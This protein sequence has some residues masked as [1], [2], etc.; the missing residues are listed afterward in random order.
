VIL[1]A[2]GQTNRFSQAVII[3]G[4]STTNADAETAGHMEINGGVNIFQDYITVGR[5]NGT[6]VTAPDRLVS[7]LTVNGGETTAN[8]FWMGAMLGNETT[9]TA[10]RASRSTT[11]RSARPCSMAGYGGSAR[12]RL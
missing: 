4:Q 9:L 2:T 8:G 10:R 5:G 6:A 11:A 7:T 12:P 3:G 1:G